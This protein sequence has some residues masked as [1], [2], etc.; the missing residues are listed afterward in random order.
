MYVPSLSFYP[1]FSGRLIGADASELV[2][3]CPCICRWRL[4]MPCSTQSFASQCG[5][6]LIAFAGLSCLCPSSL[7]SIGL[8]GG[9]WRAPSQTQCWR[10]QAAHLHIFLTRWFFS[11]A[12]IAWPLL[13]PPKAAERSQQSALSDHLLARSNQHVRLDVV[14]R[15]HWCSESV[16]MQSKEPR[17]VPSFLL[18]L[19]RDGGGTKVRNVSAGSDIYFGE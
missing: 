15:E 12:S 2:S 19:Q 8:A 10:R 14:G 17:G 1:T 11:F 18:I 7:A 4:P 3:T 13:L 6:S 5:L 9:T 16:A